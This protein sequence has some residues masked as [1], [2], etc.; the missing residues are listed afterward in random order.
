MDNMWKVMFRQKSDKNWDFEYF[1]TQMEAVLFFEIMATD[2]EIVCGIPVF[3][4]VS[5]VEG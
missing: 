3:E 5:K 1:G 2:P 4:E